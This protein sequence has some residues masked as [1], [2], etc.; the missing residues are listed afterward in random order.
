MK[1]FLT[2]NRFLVIISALTLIIS[3]ALIFLIYQTDMQRNSAIQDLDNLK[4]KIQRLNFSR[5]SPTKEN[6]ELINEDLKYVKLETATLEE[7]FGQVY[8]NSLNS[9]INKL[10]PT[11]QIAT[12]N[13]SIKKTGKKSQET[14]KEKAAPNNN[15]G[16]QRITI[17][18]ELKEKF[19]ESWKKFI[20]EQKKTDEALEA[21]EVLN[22]F[23]KFKKYSENKFD[24][25]KKAFLEEFKKNT[26]EKVNNVNIDDYILAALGFPLDFTRI[27]CKKFV[28][29]VK[30]AIETK[31][32]TEKILTKTESLVLFDE[33]TTIPN[34]DQIPYIIKYCR[35]YEDLFTRLADSRVETLTS[36][37]KLNGLRGTKKG[38][39]LI[40]QYELQ[41]IAPL[42]SVRNFINSL[43]NAF[44]DNRIYK[45]KNISINNISS[46]AEKLQPKKKNIT[47]N[48]A[49]NTQEAL[50]SKSAAQDES[51]KA[52]NKQIVI[53]LGTSN[54]VK[55][56]IE[57][58]YIIYNKP[59]ISI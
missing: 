39:Y 28:E 23:R 12:D 5:P 58:D 47:S 4:R 11:D 38:D 16:S 31:L 41:F 21:A 30:R 33:F 19:I 43:Q 59:L 9:F 20:E 53:L 14:I 3:L 40:F 6:I 36:Y 44:Q 46:K 26:L 29:D 48:Q 1:E 49:S 45:I 13:N 25:A 15:T 42:N 10:A 55:I 27:S 22:N 2:K 57:F 7:Y 54:L 18:P 24:E 37:K 34:D 8:N 17:S 52:D 35:L 56:N 51:S 32:R 50:N